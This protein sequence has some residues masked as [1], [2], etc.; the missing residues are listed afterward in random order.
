MALGLLV[1]NGSLPVLWGYSGL[2]AR[3]GVV[4]FLGQIGSLQQHGFS[5]L[6]LAQSPGS[7]C[8]AILA[9]HLPARPQKQ[10]GMIARRYTWLNRRGPA[11][12]RLAFFSGLCLF[13]GLPLGPEQPALVLVVK[14]SNI[15][16]P[17]Q[18]YLSVIQSF[19]QFGAGGLG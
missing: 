6:N 19:N 14:M 12:D 11:L 16:G 17:V 3:F 13:F 7:D 18:G 10:R 15:F 1:L 5:F 2:V 8:R 4:V 9:H